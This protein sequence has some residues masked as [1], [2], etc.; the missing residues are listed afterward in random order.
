MALNR[1]ALNSIVFANQQNDHTKSI[2]EL[3]GFAE[4]GDFRF[5]IFV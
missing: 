2:W 3:N 4:I 1:I 5:F